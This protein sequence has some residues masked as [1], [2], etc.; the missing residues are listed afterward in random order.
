[1][2]ILPSALDLTDSPY[3]W[4]FWRQSL[5]AG[6]MPLIFN[7]TILNGMGVVGYIETKPS[8]VPF[9]DSGRLLD[10]QFTYSDV[11]WP[12]T[13]FLGLHL[14][15]KPEGNRYQGTIEGK[16]L[17]K[18][19]SPPAKGESSPRRWD[20]ELPLKVAVI[21]TPPREKRIL[22]DQFH[23]VRYPPG[24]IPRDS[25]DVRNDILDWHGDHLHTNYHGMFDALRDAGYYVE[26]LGSPLTCFDATQYGTLLMV[27]LEDE[28]YSE[29]IKKLQDDVK[30]KGLGLIVFAD[31]YHVE[32]MVKMKFFDDNTRS[33]WTPATGGANI[34]ALNDLLAPFGIAFG[35]TILNGAY[36]IGGERAHY[37]SGTDIL[38]FPA[39]GFVH[40]FLFQDSSGG[41]SGI[42]S[43]RSSVRA[44][45]IPSDEYFHLRNTVL[46]IICIY[47]VD[48]S[49]RLQ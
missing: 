25:L 7:A 37:A 34:P 33:W 19:V 44:Q 30:M 9:D 16:I 31:W 6:A 10:I 45:V 15:I 2:S 5:Y 12:W 3:A 13:G 27:D 35:D 42:T 22:W 41:R 48:V 49:C 36:S 28:Y 21:P 18:V 20:C 46:V 1:V 32:T 38:R 29:E 23:S 17:F 11:I 14:R 39:G 8:W 40:R 47:I 24:Y 43:S 26:T 4:P